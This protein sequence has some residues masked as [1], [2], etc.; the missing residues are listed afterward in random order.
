M[1]I[2]QTGSLSGVKRHDYLPFG[3]DLAAGV[4]GRTTAQGYSQSDNVRQ[5]FTGQERDAETGL[6]YMKARYFSNA[7]GRFTSPDP[8]PIKK[9]HL[10]DPRDLNRYAY[11]ANNP[12]KY[13]DPTGLEKIIVIV[14]THIPAQT[15]THP[16][17][18][19]P[20]F[21]GD[22]NQRG[23]RVSHR[24][25]QKIVIETDARRPNAN[26]FDHFTNVGTTHRE[27]RG[28]G[29]VRGPSEAT[30]DGSTLQAGATRNNG[31]T[32][33]INTSGNEANPLVPGSPGIS[34]HINITVQ[35]DGADGNVRV[36]VSGTHDGFPAYE[37]VVE[38]PE[39]GNTSNTVYLHDPN[40]TGDGP[41][42]L[43]P[44]EEYEIKQPDRIIEPEPRRRRS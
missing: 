34:Y 40:K 9:R 14:R 43:F 2:D 22:N 6:D 11:V 12:L 37:V 30:A 5:K 3:E 18:V 39:S 15:V 44:P 4:G 23:E 13:I 20:T 7:Q 29:S 31:N 36:G 38:R 10:L 8:M 21:R 1:V 35:S 27:A 28:L 24:S 33:T 19:G 25:E 41:G 42:S 32:V 17:G 16:P 26:N